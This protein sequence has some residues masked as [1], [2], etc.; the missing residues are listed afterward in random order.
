MAMR[1]ARPIADKVLRKIDRYQ[2]SKVVD[3]KEFREGKQR[4]KSLEQSVT[5]DSELQKLHPAHALY[6]Y[7]QNRLSVMA[8]QL[9]HLPELDRLNRPLSEAEDAY[10]PQGPPMSP[11][12]ASFYTCWTLFDLSVGIANETLCTVSMAVGRKHGMHPDLLKLFSVMQDSHMGVFRHEG[13]DR[14]A[15][16]LRDLVT[17]EVSSAIC[18]SGYSGQAGELWYV[19]LLPPPA[20]EFEHHVIFTTPYRLLAPNEAEWLAYFDRALPPPISEK[21]IGAYKRHMKCGPPRDY[22]SEFVFEA[23]VNYESN[24]IFLQGLPDIEESRPFSRINDPL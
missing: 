14:G 8:E 22:W 13:L 18:T 11:L 9:T 21:R 1:R 6:V 7:A 23:Y 10:M 2:R 12:T 4:A 16:I 15:V 19:R 5:S 3:L 20:P 24:V 17:N